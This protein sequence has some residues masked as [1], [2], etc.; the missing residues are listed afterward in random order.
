[1]PSSMN[2][3]SAM[4]RPPIAPR[5]PPPSARKA[6]GTV[7]LVAHVRRDLVVSCCSGGG[8]RA[9]VSTTTRSG[10][11]G[12]PSNFDQPLLNEPA[13]HPAACRSA[14]AR[15]RLALE[16]FRIEKPHEE[17]EVSGSAFGPAWQKVLCLPRGSDLSTRPLESTAA[18]GC[19]ERH[20]TNA[21]R[22]SGK[23][24]GTREATLRS[25]W[26]LNSLPPPRQRGGVTGKS[27]HPQ[28]T[29]ARDFLLI[30]VRTSLP[31]PP[32]KGAGSVTRNYV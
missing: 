18:R 19:C 25:P 8:A 23:A 14:V 29:S 20:A 12:R 9:A 27:P 21:R 10:K 17:T 7:H 32:R 31:R 24:P 3:S 6:F 22:T 16:P 5:R 15:P 28:H 11:S 30:A 1:M 2:D 4:L 26:G 13:H